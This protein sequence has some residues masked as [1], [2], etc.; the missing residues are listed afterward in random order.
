MKTFFSSVRREFQLIFRNGITIF[1]VAAPAI[2]AFVFIL[3]FGAVNETTMRLAVDNTLDAALVG[4]LE[5]VAIVERFDDTARMEARVR[6]TDAVAGVTMQNGAV[7]AVFEGNEGQSMIDAAEKLIGLAV[8]A[9]EGGAA[10]RSEPVEAKGGVAYTLSMI[11]V[12]LMALFIGGATVGLSIV[13]ERESGAIRAVSVSPMRLS[14]YVETKLAPALVLGLVGICAAALI[15]GKA[16]IVPRYLLLA[17]ASVLVS[18]MMTFAIGSFASNQ[19]A[20]IGV[21]KLL[22]PL[23]MIL[24]VSAMFVPDKW[25]FFYYV[26]PM[27]WQYRALRAVLAGTAFLWPAL[28]TL[29]VGVPWFLLAVLHFAKKTKFRMGR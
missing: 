17:L 22:I 10:Y 12:L 2:L 6:A 13:D 5:R 21:L 3:V 23:S 4:R 7:T 16:E 20:A 9:P 18:G 8:D 25:Q 28:L 15:I 14:A 29:L 1:M 26:L 27:Y 11:S 19:I 24:P